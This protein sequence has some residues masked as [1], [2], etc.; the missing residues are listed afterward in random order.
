MIDT[1]GGQGFGLSDLY[2][3][4]QLATLDSGSAL[5][6]TKSNVT[7]DQA[8]ALAIGPK[9]PA[10]TPFADAAKVMSAAPIEIIANSQPG[11]IARNLANVDLN[12]M[13]QAKKAALANRVF[14]YLNFSL[15]L[16]YL[17]FIRCIDSTKYYFR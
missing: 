6:L 15:K 5:N 16:F 1:F 2:K 9:L 8:S 7:F 11:D 3:P 12:N 17:Y 14:F 4:T 13:G 10:N